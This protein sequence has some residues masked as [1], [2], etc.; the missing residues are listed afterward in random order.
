[1]TN[2]IMNASRLIKE[3]K[4]EMYKASVEVERAL[5]KL[6]S[7]LRNKDGYEGRYEAVTEMIAKMYAITDSFIE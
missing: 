2:N 5:K 7:Q 1:M 6:R 4:N 3:E